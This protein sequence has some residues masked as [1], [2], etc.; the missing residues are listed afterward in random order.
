[1]RGCAEMGEDLAVLYV[2]PVDLKFAVPTFTKGVKV[3]QPAR[4]CD[5]DRVL[6][7][8]YTTGPERWWPIQA[9]VG[10]EWGNLRDRGDVPPFSR[11]L[12]GV[13]GAAFR[14]FVCLGSDNLP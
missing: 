10:L 11:P 1:V 7:S 3:G 5:C 13:S 12:S 2:R 9:V 8:P 4:I 14:L 6:C